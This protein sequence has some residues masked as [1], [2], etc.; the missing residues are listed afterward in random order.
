MSHVKKTYKVN[1]MSC[2]SC[3]RSVETILKAQNGVQNAAVNLAEN[4]V[5][6]D[7]DSTSIQGSGI[8]TAVD[9]IGFE[10]QLEEES[11]EEGE[12]R[13]LRL[14]LKIYTALILALPIL[15]I[16]M[17]FKELVYREWIL[18]I[19]STPV[20]FWSGGHFFLNAIKKLRHGITNMD[21]LVSLGTGIAFLYSLVLT[22][23][24][25]Y[26][27]ISGVE[28][29]VYYES[30]VVVITLVLLGNLMEQKAKS[31]TSKSL[32]KLIS[33]QAKKALVV[34]DGTE[35]EMEV[36]Q[37]QS[38]YVLKIK[39]G[40]KIPLDGTIQKG[41]SFLDE[42][43]VTGESMP[44]Q[45]EKGDKVIGGTLNQQGALLVEVTET[46]ENTVLSKIIAYVQEAQM[47]KAPI[48]KLV[49]RIASV[50]VPVVVA[51]AIIT[52]GIW[53]FCWT[54]TCI[55]TFLDFNGQCV[56]DCMSLRVG[57]GYSNGYYCGNGKRG[58]KWN[59]GEGC[60]SAGVV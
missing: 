13:G 10:L 29:E 58:V 9:S 14:H 42:S 53:F 35:K 1:G 23:F 32:K 19:L 20:V 33:L 49:D 57:I 36:G 26:F 24:P 22:L 6:V 27:S 11:D 21:T 12:R 34:L 46:G 28:A 8:K 16:S 44:V 2:A 56:G 30:A 51:I 18:L 25:S 47:R 55:D 41:S 15:A 50:F 4:S 37:I 40:E 39:P 60:R 52:F 54:R 48:Q 3:V 43:M 31:N 38:G 7:F 59:L 45:K 17:L 5:Q